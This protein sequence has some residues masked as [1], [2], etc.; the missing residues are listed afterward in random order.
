MD[1]GEFRQG[2]VAPTQQFLATFDKVFAVLEDNDAAKLQ[3]LGFGSAEAGL[4]DAD[5]EKL[6]ADRNAAKKK[7]DFAAA[8]RIRKELADRGIILE[9]AKDGS[10]RWKRK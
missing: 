10:V 9:D 7:R 3:A 6:I 5:I 8:D 4:S 2:D 1:R